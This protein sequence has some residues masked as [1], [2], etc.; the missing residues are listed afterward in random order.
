M[1]DPKKLKVGDRIRFVSLPDEWQDPKF[2]IFEECM[3][4]M[5]SRNWPSRIYEIDEYG[6]PWIT[7]RVRVKGQIEHH[8]WEISEATGWRLVGKRS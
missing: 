6:T 1:P 2:T 7:A 5:I 8:T 4:I 3:E